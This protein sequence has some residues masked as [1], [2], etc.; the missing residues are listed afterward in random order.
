ML[1]SSPLLFIV[2]SPSGAGKTTLT[3][4]L[5]LRLE[6]L[7]FSVSHTT[8]RPRNNE[9][10]GREYH[11]VTRDQFVSLIEQGSFLE[12]A[13]VHGNLYGTS[14][15]ELDRAGA[16]RGIIFDVDYQGAR[17][18]KSHLPDSVSVFILPPDMETLHARLSG[19]ASEDSA[20]V[21][22]RFSVALTEIAHYGLF[23][24]L[25]VNDDLE[26]ATQRLIA[27]FLAEECRRYRAAQVAERL[28]ADGLGY[29]GSR[30]PGSV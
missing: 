11:F 5:M 8:R 1:N 22:R 23:D 24:Y 3:S 28:L 17:Q 7:S 29:G 26:A 4:R 27:I 14:R 9:Q 15:T 30:P 13:E 18:I 21:A 6:R 20:T 12:W 19:R 2:S 10:D 16:Q 25:L